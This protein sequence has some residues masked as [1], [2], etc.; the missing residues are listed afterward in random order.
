[1]GKNIDWIKDAWINKHLGQWTFYLNRITGVVIAL[2]LIPHL[3]VN[4]VALLGGPEAY[5]NVLKAMETPLLRIFEV[6][7]VTAVAFHMFN[8]IRILLIDYFKLSRQQT[9]LVV[10][11]FLL[12]I[13]IFAGAVYV[14]WDDIVHPSDNH[15]NQTDIH[16]QSEITADEAETVSDDSGVPNVPNSTENNH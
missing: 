3:F 6:L 11:V 12:T 14:Y 13:M 10:F 1:M 9:V 2:Y 15:H 4:S 16:S 8:G 5:S 7:L